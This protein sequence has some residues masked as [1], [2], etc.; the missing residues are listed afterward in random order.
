MAHRFPATSAKFVIEKLK[1]MI[2]KDRV[3]SNRVLARRLL[4]NIVG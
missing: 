2:V 3:P 4:R 1:D